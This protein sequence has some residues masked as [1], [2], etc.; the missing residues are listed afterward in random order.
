MA[1][2]GRG[3]IG[4]PLTQGSIILGGAGDISVELPIGAASTVLTSDGTTASWQPVS[5][6]AITFQDGGAPVAGAPHTTVNFT[7]AGVTASD[8]GG[9]TLDV[10]IPGGGVSDFVSLTDT[11]GSITANGVL[12]G[13]GAGSALLNLGPGANGEVLTIVAGAPAWQPAPSGFADPMTTIGDIIIR[14]GTNTTTR[15]PIGAASTVLTSD[16]TTASWQPAPSG[17]ADPMTTIGD[18]IIRDGTNTTT[19]LPV[20][21]NGEVLTVSGGVPSWQPASGGSNVETITATTNGFGQITGVTSSPAGWTVGFTT[22]TISVTSHPVGT[23][24]INFT[25]R[26]TATS[27]SRPALRTPAGSTTFVDITTVGSAFDLIAANSGPNNFVNG[28]DITYYL[29][30]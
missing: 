26:G 30:F 29:F 19:R 2:L 10:T 24:P 9:G 23:D 14:D 12:I 28:D 11:P 20:G 18:I 4:N 6:G 27:S 25:I 16:G 5:G 7:G 3:A 1:V 13:N 15:L 17:F 8:A 21:A 22:T